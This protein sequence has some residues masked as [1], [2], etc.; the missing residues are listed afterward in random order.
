[1]GREQARKVGTSELQTW[2]KR[3]FQQN[4]TTLYGHEKFI[5][6][7]G[8]NYL[9]GEANRVGNRNVKV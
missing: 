1:M 2:H 5:Q 9:K 3:R 4:F 6:L 8:I 7:F